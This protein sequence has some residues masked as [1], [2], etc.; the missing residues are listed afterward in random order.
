MEFAFAALLSDSAETS[1]KFLERITNE[2]HLLKIVPPL[3][4]AYQELDTAIVN[5]APALR[6]L[7]VQLGGLKLLGLLV[8]CT[9][10]EF[11]AGSTADGECFADKLWNAASG[12]DLIEEAPQPYLMGKMLMDMGV[13]PGKQMGEIIKKSFE[14]QLDGE[15][16]NAE[17][18]IAWARSAIST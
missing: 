6:R 15:I 12:L 16:K 14:L 7:A 13:K 5:D 18:A 1:L 11:Y 4:K 17:E 10:C 8:K 2:T 9:P 3:L